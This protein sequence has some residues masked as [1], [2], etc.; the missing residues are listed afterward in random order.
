ME[1]C[2]SWHNCPQEY[3][4]TSYHGIIILFV[5]MAPEHMFYLHRRTSHIGSCWH[6]VY[7]IFS[8]SL[9]PVICEHTHMWKWPNLSFQLWRQCFINLWIL[10]ALFLIIMVAATSAAV[11]WQF[12]G[13]ILLIPFPVNYICTVSC[14]KWYVRE[15]QPQVSSVQGMIKSPQYTGGDYVF[16]PVHTLSPTT[17]FFHVVTSEQHF[18]FL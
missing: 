5:F 11:S 10:T 14:Q 13:W 12:A 3:F 9:W 7:G 2:E 4:G 15:K 17:D 18:G 8:G 16:V 6:T 1:V